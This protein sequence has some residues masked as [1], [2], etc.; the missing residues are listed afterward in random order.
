MGKKLPINKIMDSKYSGG[1]QVT[2]SKKNI[3]FCRKN[4]T[5]FSSYECNFNN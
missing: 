3:I 4:S 1:N 2:V 5:T